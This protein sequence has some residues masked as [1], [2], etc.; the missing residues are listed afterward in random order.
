MTA[1]MSILSLQAYNQKEPAVSEA[2]E[3]AGNRLQSMMVL[4]D[5]L[6]RSDNLSEMSARDYLVTMVDEIVKIFPARIPIKTEMAID[7]FVLPIK[8]LSPIGI[9]VNELITNAIKYAFS[10]RSDGIISVSAV[11]RN[12]HAMLIIAD[13]GTGIPETVDVQNSD[14]FGL[15]LVN[16]LT[17]QIKGTLRIEREKGT[18]FVLELDV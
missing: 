5:K 12:G 4:Y 6:Y 7:D 2:L 8:L 10:D 14:G 9:I 11:K 15:Y 18:R 3:S 13:N 16:M 17:R 1:M